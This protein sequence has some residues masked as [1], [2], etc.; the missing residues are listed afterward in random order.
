MKWCKKVCSF[1]LGQCVQEFNSL[2]SELVAELRDNQGKGM[3]H[4]ASILLCVCVSYYPAETDLKKHLNVD[5]FFPTYSVE[6]N[7]NQ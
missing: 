7:L 5:H 6:Q 2:C 4:E 1:R 3:T